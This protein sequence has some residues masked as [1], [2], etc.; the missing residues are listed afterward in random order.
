[1]LKK[2]EV[3]KS[4]PN[5]N[6]NFIKTEKVIAKREGKDI[7]WERVKSHDSV[8][9]LVVNKD[10]EELLLVKQVRIPVLINDSSQDG[11]IY[12]MC[13]G[14]VDKEHTVTQIAKEE[15]LEELGYEVPIRNIRKLKTL[16]SGVGSSGSNS[17]VFFCFVEES[18]KVSEGGGLENEDI[19]V[20]RFK[21]N[22]VYNFVF[23]SQKHTDAVT[24][25]LM[26]YW[27]LEG[28]TL[29]LKG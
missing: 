22:E 27:L 18:Q 7:I 8:H 14:L 3:I 11:V 12:E 6:P 26:S 20:V 2:V 25:F 1:M 28:R 19:E 9:I 29:L 23:N 4:E 21:F 5:D 10:T 24:A 13:A 15:V 17:H 16:K